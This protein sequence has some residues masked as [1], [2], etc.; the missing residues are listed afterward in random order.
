[1]YSTHTHLHMH[2]Q[3]VQTVPV[4]ESGSVGTICIFPFFV[5]N[6]TGAGFATSIV[7]SKRDQ[8][9]VDCD[10]RQMPLFGLSLYLL[11]LPSHTSACIKYFFATFQ[12]LLSDKSLWHDEC[13][14]DRLPETRSKRLHVLSF[15]L[16]D[17]SLHYWRKS[18]H[19][20]TS[21]DDDQCTVPSGFSGAWVMI[22]AAPTIPPG[23][24]CKHAQGKR[25]AETYLLR[26]PG[27][28]L[29]LNR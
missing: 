4:R 22:F 15:R 24:Q 26:L 3:V 18:K 28:V 14:G 7:V 8:T 25:K 2:G 13:A 5:L 16:S 1:M 6:P 9:R 17:D 29:C 21:A 27:F 10:L 19:I 20:S 11:P 23:K 12:R